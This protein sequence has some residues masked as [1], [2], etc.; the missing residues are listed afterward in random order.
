MV[1]T[2][3][4]DR[5]PA[6]N[7]RKFAQGINL[8]D[9][10]NVRKALCCSRNGVCSIKANIRPNQKVTSFYC[11]QFNFGPSLSASCNCKAGQSLRCS[12]VCILLM[13]VIEAT[14]K[15]I[16]GSLC[17]HKPCTWNAA[18]ETNVIP[19]TMEDVYSQAASRR[20]PCSSQQ[21]RKW[22]R[23]FK[24]PLWTWISWRVLYCVVSW[25]PQNK[26]EELKAPVRVRK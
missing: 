18:K 11:T 20:F 19:G 8:F 25:S 13:K 24:S 10:G 14:N 17:T 12:P 3:D 6:Q 16:T 9:S 1:N 22:K 2:I 7:C 15:A 26:L 23:T 4:R 21:E 5:K